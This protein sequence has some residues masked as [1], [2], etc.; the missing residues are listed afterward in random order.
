MNQHKLQL[1]WIYWQHL[2]CNFIQQVEQVL[3]IKHHSFA[4]NLQ[5]RIFW[6]LIQ[7]WVGTV[8]FKSKSGL[9][10]IWDGSAWSRLRW[11]SSRESKRQWLVLRLHQC[12]V[13]LGLHR[14]AYVACLPCVY[15]GSI[16]GPLSFA[17]PIAPIDNVIIAYHPHQYAEDTQTYLAVSTDISPFETA[18]HCVSDFAH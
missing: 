14:K 17:R 9:R 12:I 16:L 6:N 7:L 8:S 15:E 18:S 2:V 13:C 11:G 4:A 1:V 10:I 5:N 3:N